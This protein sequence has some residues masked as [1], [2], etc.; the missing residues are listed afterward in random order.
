MQCR[1]SRA[2]FVVPYAKYMKS[3]S[4]MISVGA[5]FNM[6][7]CMDESPELRFIVVVTGVADMDPYK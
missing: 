5:R 6:K 2:D 1:S 7:L 3:V 4:S